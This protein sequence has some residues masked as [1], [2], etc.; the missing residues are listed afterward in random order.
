MGINNETYT[1]PR[2]VFSKSA[3]LLIM[4]KI[5]IS[6][7]MSLVVATVEA[8][9]NYYPN[10]T[11]TIAKSGYTYKYENAPGFDE[12]GQSVSLQLYS[13][14]SIYLNV[15]WAYKD[16]TRMSNVVRIYNNFV[17]RKAVACFI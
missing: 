6:L 15:E 8:Q 14:A 7:I 4:K 9:T 12:P 16:G 17:F 11:D 1:E 10:T 2:P 3:K 13:A 5:I